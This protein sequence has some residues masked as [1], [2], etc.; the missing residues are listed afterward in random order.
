MEITE[1]T[2]YE[3]ALQRLKEIV[4]QLEAKEVK[5]DKLS[6]TVLEAK[7]LVDFCRKKLDKTEEDIKRIIDPESDHDGGEA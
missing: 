3:E 4:N 5:I 2:T 6:E 7:G 1:K